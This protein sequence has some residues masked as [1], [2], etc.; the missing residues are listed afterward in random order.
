MKEKTKETKRKIAPRTN[1]AGNFFFIFCLQAYVSAFS[2]TQAVRRQHSERVLNI[3]LNFM[4]LMKIH[5]A[6]PF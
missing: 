1:F 2:L 6:S 5:R 4:K 3:K